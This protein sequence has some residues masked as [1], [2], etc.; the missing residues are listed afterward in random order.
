MKLWKKN[1]YGLFFKIWKKFSLILDDENNNNFYEG[2]LLLIPENRIEY[3]LVYKKYLKYK[4][5]YLK[6]KQKYL[7]LKM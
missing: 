5:K 3:K 1:K 2:E 7:K 6:Y 4:Q